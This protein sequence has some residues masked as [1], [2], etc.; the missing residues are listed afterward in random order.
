MEPRWFV[1]TNDGF[2]G[3]AQGYG[4][5]SPAKLYKAYWFFKNRGKIEDAQ[6]LAQT[7]LGKN[8][9][10]KAY[11]DTY[12]SEIECFYRLK[13]GDSTSIKDLIESSRQEDTKIVEKLHNN[14]NLWKSL[15]NIYLNK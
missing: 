8:L 14:V 2:D 9:D 4:Y 6:R 3:A 12:F 13:E 7:F 10:V 11:L 15:E 5:K 1:E